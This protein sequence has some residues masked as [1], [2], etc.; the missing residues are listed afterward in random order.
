MP[1]FTHRL[2]E[3]KSWKAA[4]SCW[5]NRSHRP[6]LAW[7]SAS[8][9]EPV[10]S[11]CVAHAF[12]IGFL[13]QWHNTQH[14]CMLS[15][16]PRVWCRMWSPLS[17]GRLQSHGKNPGPHSS[18]PE[19]PAP[20]RPTFSLVLLDMPLLPVSPGAWGQSVHRLVRPFTRHSSHIYQMR[21]KPLGVPSASHVSTSLSVP[22]VTG[23]KR[24]EG[25]R[26]PQQRAACP[27]PHSPNGHITVTGRS[28][29]SPAQSECWHIYL[30]IC[31]PPQVFT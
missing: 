16:P 20:K 22:P 17:R 2:A 1:L 26:H 6:G 19:H 31:H 30:Q 15:L 10:L 3:V 4:R 29:G 5:W 27:R 25:T 12:L 9:Q 13:G 23:Y 24:Q 21:D 11:P 18:C 7:L 14:A 8:R 28:W